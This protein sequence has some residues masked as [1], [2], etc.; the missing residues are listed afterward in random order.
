M[1]AGCFPFSRRRVPGRRL[2]AL[3]LPLA[4]P[5]IPTPTAALTPAPASAERCLAAQAAADRD[6]LRGLHRQLL[7]RPPRPE[8]LAPLLERAGQ[9]LACGAPD[10]ALAVLDRLSPA[11][12]AD[13]QAW[14]RLRWQAAAA[15]LQH[16]LA[17]ETLLRLAAGDPDGLESLNLPL[18]GGASR[19]GR[20]LLADHLEAL[21]WNEWAVAVLLGGA[22]QADRAVAAARL[23]RVLDLAEAWLPQRRQA[24]LERAL[25]QAAAAGA[26]GLAA[27]LL[28]RQL[29]PLEDRGAEPSLSGEAAARRRLRLSGRIDDLYGEWRLR[30]ALA[31]ADPR[32]AEL[33]RQL[34]SPRSPGGHAAATSQAQP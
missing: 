10:G 4:L 32:A 26:W 8:P 7:Q 33:E 16:R 30:R 34:R 27:L 28:D 22:D 2:L 12:G 25:D 5:T 18:Q 20:D 3:I 14:L 24:L 17:A 9:L 29:G 15:G 31:P 11:P 13:R 19:S 6:A 1:Q 23:A 21:G